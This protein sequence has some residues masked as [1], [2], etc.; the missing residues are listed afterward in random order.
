MHPLLKPY[1]DLVSFL[2]QVL[3][4]NCEIVLHD[5]QDMEHS[6]VA[7]ANGHISGRTVGAPMN[8]AGLAFIKSGA[9]QNRDAYVNYAGTSRGR[10]KIRCSVKFIKDE[11]G[12]LIGMLCLN[13]A[14]DEYEHCLDI[15]SEALHLREPP[16]ALALPE[17]PDP[18]EERFQTSIPEVVTSVLESVLEQ[19]HLPVDRLS[20]EEKIKVVETLERKGVFLFKGAVSEVATQL[21]TSEP[22][23]YRYLAK[24]QKPS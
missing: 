21:L 3:D 10:G 15:L 12:E 8:V 5:T 19:A 23:I 20:P 9:H 13:Y 17:H 11:R 7:I 22:T 16:K 24:L 6:I 14:Y 18:L 2:G 4:P 1:G